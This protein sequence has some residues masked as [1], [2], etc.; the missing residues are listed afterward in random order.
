MKV[1]RLIPVAVALVAAGG[2]ALV[3]MNMMSTPAP[4]VQ[5]TV[6]PVEQQL[7]VGILV[8][9][10]DFSMGGRITEDSIR[11][12][13]WPEDAVN[14]NADLVRQ[15]ERP[16]GKEDF[17]ANIALANIIEGEPVTSK[18]FVSAERGFLS[19][20]L[21]EGKLAMATDISLA[22]GAG[23]F[24]LPNDHVDVLM[25][26]ESSNGTVSTESLFE[27]IR[28]LAI[29]QTLREEDGSSVVEGN[30]ATLELTQDQVR[31]LAA[32]RAEDAN[33]S[34][35]LRSLSD[36]EKPVNTSRQRLS[37]SVRMINGG[38]VST[39]TTD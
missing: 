34:L 38:A 26:L 6:Q 18:K 22:T 24:I 39:A 13:Q 12:Q 4:V 17:M 33:I 14:S 3:A 10:K 2:A 21:P 20:L 35:A 23:G 37:G 25:S 5:A 30:T 1:S 31:L 19:A 28:V 8:A 32:A 15:D 29:G 36:K 7:T 16:D 9:A 27:N 11:W